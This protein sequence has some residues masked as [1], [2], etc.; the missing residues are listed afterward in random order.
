MWDAVKGG[1]GVLT[2]WETYAAGL[3][4]LAL[5]MIPTGL[6]GYFAMK[7]E[8]AGGAIGCLSMLVLPA[9]G[10]FAIVVFVLTLSPIILGLSHDAAWAFPWVLA[11]K[12]PWSMVK[13]VGLLLI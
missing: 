2:Y 6:A 7:S 3:E 10:A 1:L 9:V 11:I 5:Y 8:R 12:A 4:Y 13:F